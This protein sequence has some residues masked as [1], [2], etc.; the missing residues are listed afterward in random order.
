MEMINEWVKAVGIKQQAIITV[1]CISM[2]GFDESKSKL[3]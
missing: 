1:S 2:Y 3:F